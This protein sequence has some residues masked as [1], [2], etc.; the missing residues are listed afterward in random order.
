V[1]VVVG[2]VGTEPGRL[3]GIEPGV[4]VLGMELAGVLLV[5][6]LE[7]ELDGFCANAPGTV[8]LNSAIIGRL[9]KR[10]WVRRT[11]MELPTFV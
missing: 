9:G 1:G 8:M 3:V 2:F 7:L 11:C 5:L 10:R 6:V 4:R